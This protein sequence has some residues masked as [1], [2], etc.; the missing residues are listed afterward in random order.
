MRILPTDRS[1]EYTARGVVHAS[2]I[3][4]YV[5]TGKIFRLSFSKPK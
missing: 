2:S 3:L 4:Y 1:Q 5:E